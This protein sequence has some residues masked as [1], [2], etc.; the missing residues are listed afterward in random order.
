MNSIEERVARCF[1][2][3]FPD[4]R[5]DEIPQASMERLAAWD[6]VAHVTLLSSLSEEFGHSFELED[7]EELIS[8]PRIL[9]RLENKARNG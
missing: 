6:S 5:E 3:V 9:D 1:S 2:N 4:L 7:F 8:Y